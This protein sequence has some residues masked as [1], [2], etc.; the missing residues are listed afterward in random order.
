M[1]TASLKLD[2]DRSIMF[3][4]FGNILG[5]VLNPLKSSSYKHL[6]PDFRSSKVENTK[7][8]QYQLRQLLSLPH[9]IPQF[10]VWPQ[11]DPTLTV[12]GVT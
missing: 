11:K 10:P 2:F 3:V 8:T 12:T 6:G 7:S 1:S 5:L 9:K 4:H